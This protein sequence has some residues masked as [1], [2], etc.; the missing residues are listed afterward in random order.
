MGLYFIGE[1]DNKSEKQ[2]DSIVYGI[3]KIESGKRVVDS[4]GISF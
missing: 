1:F 2:Q 4:R 3:T